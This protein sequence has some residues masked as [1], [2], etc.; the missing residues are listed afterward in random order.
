MRA[1]LPPDESYLPDLPTFRSNLSIAQIRPLVTVEFQFPS[2]R[3]AMREGR[4]YSDPQGS[5]GENL[6]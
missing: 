1:L 6:P 4:R 5:G 3:L 2:D